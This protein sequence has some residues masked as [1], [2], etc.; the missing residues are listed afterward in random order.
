[1]SLILS[2]VVGAL[3]A[4]LINYLSDVLPISRR[5]SQPICHNCGK[6]FPTKDYLFSF[7]C[8][9]CGNRTSARVIL[10]T[11]FS[12]IAS[13]LVTL[14]PLDGISYWATLPILVF[15]GVI[16]VIDIEFR[17]VLK[18]TSYMGLALFL[19]YGILMHGISFTFL[20]GVAGFLIMMALYY[21]GILFNKLMGRF[22][23][24][25]IDEVAL[26]FG[27][28]YVGAF[29]GFFTGWPLIISVLFFA[30]IASGVF[31]LFYILVMLLL[32]RYRTFSAIPYTPFLIL[33][34]IAMLYISK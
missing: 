21:L 16:L 13:I 3:M 34:S 22:R 19:V 23:G 10:V 9:N 15:L 5:F 25:E 7:R 20:G 29:L 33:A 28:V 6:L 31:S 32:R 1:M 4:V 12:I 2:A 8:P 26:G 11:I 27:D 30:I 17:V 18:E 24:Q 14:Y